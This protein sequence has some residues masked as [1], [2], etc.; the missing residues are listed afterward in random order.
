M[1]D[2]RLQ[3]SFGSHMADIYIFYSILPVCDVI[4]FVSNLNSVSSI[5]SFYQVP[6]FLYEK[7]TKV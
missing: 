7:L 6:F 2:F 4:L 1:T 3:L 5:I